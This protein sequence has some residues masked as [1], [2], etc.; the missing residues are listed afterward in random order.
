MARNRFIPVPNR[1]NKVITFSRE[2][3]HSFPAADARTASILEHFLLRR[4][5]QKGTFLEFE[6][7][8]GATA[9]LSEAVTASL[10]YSETELSSTN[11]GTVIQT[12]TLPTS[13]AR[14]GATINVKARIAPTVPAGSA[15]NV[16]QG[17]ATQTANGIAPVVAPVT[18][19]WDEGKSLWFGLRLNRTAASQV[20]VLYIKAEA[21]F[22]IP[23]VRPAQY[24]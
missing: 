6:A 9:A 16:L 10:V 22:G 19:T 11:L 24:S 21:I 20:D 2:P 4:H 3:Q 12:F 15:S 23:N 18:L 13:A 17:V 14:N 8:F 5:D 1:D 7:V